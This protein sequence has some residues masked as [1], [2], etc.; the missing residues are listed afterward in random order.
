M[1]R[2]EPRDQLAVILTAEAERLQEM[3]HF[4]VE[5][6]GLE[7]ERRWVDER[8]ALAW[9]DLRDEALRLKLARRDALSALPE[10]PTQGVSLLVEV[11]DVEGRARA[12]ARRAPE[13]LIER[14]DLGVA[15]ARVIRDPA[16]NAL[17]FIRYRDES[18]NRI[19]EL[20][21]DGG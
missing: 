4:Y 7:E 21:P 1:A 5:V 17:W 13:L 16:G 6:A 9:V 12:I 3:A 18:P 14:E 2:L 20:T 19:G 11:Q 15:E 10:A 8:G